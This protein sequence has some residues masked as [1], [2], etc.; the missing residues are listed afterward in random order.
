MWQAFLRLAQDYKTFV[1]T[2]RELPFLGQAY[3]GTSDIPRLKLAP[4]RWDLLTHI[5]AEAENLFLTVHVDR[6][7]VAAP[8]VGHEK[9]R[10]LLA[11]YEHDWPRVGQEANEKGLWAPPSNCGPLLQLLTSDPS[12]LV[13]GAS[14]R[15]GTATGP[16]R[17]SL[18]TL[19]PEFLFG[20]SKGR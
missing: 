17:W 11:K 18:C 14:I 15:S 13:A 8:V 16:R 2:Q 4:D 7:L 10:A 6:N 1:D 12:H 19:L 5:V 9:A 3:I 20:V